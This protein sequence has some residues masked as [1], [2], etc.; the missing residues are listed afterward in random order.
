MYRGRFNQS[1][2]L[3]EQNILSKNINLY[4]G[5]YVGIYCEIEMCILQGQITKRYKLFGS[6]VAKTHKLMQES[7]SLEVF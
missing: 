4:L 5:R 1:L 2:S 6:F 7:V 3:S